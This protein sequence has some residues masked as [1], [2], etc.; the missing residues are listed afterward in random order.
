MADIESVSKMYSRSVDAVQSS[1]RL[2]F[3]TSNP[4]NLKDK[5]EPKQQFQTT[6]VLAEKLLLLERR[7]DDLERKVGRLC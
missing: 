7:V 1:S 5:K 4:Y 2:D 6:E 3:H